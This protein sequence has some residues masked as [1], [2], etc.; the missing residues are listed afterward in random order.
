MDHRKSCG[1]TQRLFLADHN[2]NSRREF[3][4]NT[5]PQDILTNLWE[6]FNIKGQPRSKAEHYLETITL[7][8]QL[9]KS[10]V[11]SSKAFY[12]HLQ[13][14]SLYKMSPKDYKVYV[15]ITSAL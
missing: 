3:T 7:R 15:S 2:K 4:G 6:V 5:E 12:Y 8:T 11:K 14:S 1:D 9:V 10:L 13:G